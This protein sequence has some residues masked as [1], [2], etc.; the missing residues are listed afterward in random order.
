M[1]WFILILAGLCETFAVA[2]IH[3]LSVKMSWQT[4]VFIVLGL[5][6]AL[7]LLSYA[8][9]S[10]PMGT[11]YAIWTGISVVGSALIGMFYFGESK[12]GKRIFFISLILS[13]VI[14]LKIIS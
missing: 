4:I 9:Q 13:A 10:I 12:D 11:G 8:L 2:M 6:C 5:G 3:Q 7:G 1:A 14:G